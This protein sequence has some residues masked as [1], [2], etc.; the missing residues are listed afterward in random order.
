MNRNDRLRKSSDIQRVRRK[1]ISYA[2]PLVVLQ[3]AKSDLETVR[4]GIIASRSIGGAVDR[5]LA[6]R[7]LREAVRPIRKRITPG[8]DLVLI[9]RKPILEAE[10]SNLSSAVQSLVQKASLIAE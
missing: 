1:G 8:W 3:A 9:A 4:I 2:H 7:R 5:N 10:F 6:K